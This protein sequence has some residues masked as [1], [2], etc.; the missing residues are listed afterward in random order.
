MKITLSYYEI[1]QLRINFSKTVT[2]SLLQLGK[3]RSYYNI[4]FWYIARSLIAQGDYRQTPEIQTRERCYSRH[5]R[6]ANDIDLRPV[7]NRT[8]TLGLYN[9]SHR[10]FMVIASDRYSTR[11]AYCKDL[12]RQMR[13]VSK[14]NIQRK[15]YIS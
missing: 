15:I 10:D 14:Y 2:A 8:Q 13:H 6:G 7:R 4:S 3:I 1:N 5:K 9:R 12:Q 11:P